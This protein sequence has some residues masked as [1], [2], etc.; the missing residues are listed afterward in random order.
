MR[1]FLF[2]A[3]AL[4]DAQR[5]GSWLQRKTR[6][7]EPVIIGMSYNMFYNNSVLK[8]SENGTTRPFQ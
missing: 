6:G 7:H 3:T 8:C 4:A 1:C 5:A 2:S